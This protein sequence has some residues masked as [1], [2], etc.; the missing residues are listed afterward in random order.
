MACD[1]PSAIPLAPTTTVSP[2]R[3]NA[4]PSINPADISSRARY[5]PA[6]SAASISPSVRRPTSRVTSRAPS[7]WP[8]PCSSAIAARNVASGSVLPELVS[9]CPS[10]GR[11]I[12]VQAR[13]SSGPRASDEARPVVDYT[14]ATGIQTIVPPKIKKVLRM[15]VP[16]VDADGN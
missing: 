10:P 15:L 5:A 1:P 14:D 8:K 3:R 2:R 11:R 7:S 4:A 16:R 9:R 13:S 12:S 6:A